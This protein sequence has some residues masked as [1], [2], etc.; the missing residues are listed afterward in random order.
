MV[1]RNIKSKIYNILIIIGICYV[2]F[3]VV[4]KQSNIDNV[5]TGAVVYEEVFNPDLVTPLKEEAIQEYFEEESVYDEFPTKKKHWTHMPITY[6]IPRK[7]CG[8]YE[9]HKLKFAFEDIEEAT[10]NVVKFEEVNNSDNVDI[11]IKCTFLP[12]DCYELHI[13]ITEKNGFYYTKKW[14]TYCEEYEILGSALPFV[15]NNIIS[16]AE[17]EMFGLSG[18]AE[19]KRRGPSGFYVGSCGHR[20]VEVHEILHTFGYNH[21]V[22]N[23]SIMAPKEQRFAVD[24]E[25]RKS[26]DKNDCKNSDRDIDE[27][28]IND[29]I[30]TYG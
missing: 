11:N 13:N 8:D 21:V 24:Y 14:E 6:F 28:I 29:L 1:S 18:F 3:L 17:I 10:D 4:D 19:T 2:A 22:D 16:S 5:I 27:W 12:E 7:V 20:T 9:Y 26:I 25:I 23:S 15:N 30:E